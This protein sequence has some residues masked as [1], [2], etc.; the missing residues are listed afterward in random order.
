VRHGVVNVAMPKLARTELVDRRILI[1]YRVS[2][3]AL[4]QRLS[5]AVELRQMAD[6]A[7]AGIAFRRRRTMRS[8]L[9]PARFGTSQCATH[10]VRLPTSSVPGHPAGVLALRHDST[11]RWEVWWTAAGGGHHARF[12]VVDS[13]DSLE[14]VG[15]SDDRQ[16]HLFLRAQVARSL[17]DGSMFRSVPQAAECLAADLAGLG[18][19]R[20]AHGAGQ[21]GV[22]SHLRLEPLDVT[23]LESS[24]FDRWREQCP[25]LVE[26][27]SAFSL[28]EDQLAWS[29]EGTL[30]CHM[31]PA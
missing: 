2:A 7:L 14:L 16:M 18:L 28:R 9:V 25:G 3:A 5:A 30:C 29:Q 23:R 8:R 22:W 4:E 10:F 21:G 26:F 1:L 27:D 15:D 13:A 19:L 24:F 31:V 20:T 12:R 11:S 6:C 17:P